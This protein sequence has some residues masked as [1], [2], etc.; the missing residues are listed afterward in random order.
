[1]S[2]PPLPSQPQNNMEPYITVTVVKAPI[3]TRYCQPGSDAQ[4]DAENKKIRVGGTWFDYNPISW[5]IVTEEEK[6]EN[7]LK[8]ALNNVILADRE[9]VDLVESYNIKEE[10]AM[11]WMV[12]TKKFTRLEMDY[13]WRIDD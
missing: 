11:I 5:K 8:D 2:F 3:T 9:F 1:M 7:F 10:L 12:E 6:K 4:F 13:A